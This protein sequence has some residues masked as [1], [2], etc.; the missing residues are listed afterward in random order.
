MMRSRRYGAIGAVLS[1]V[2]A[3]GISWAGPGNATTLQPAANGPCPVGTATSFGTCQDFFHFSGTLQ[4]F[5]VPSGVTELTLI[6]QGGAGA[7]RCGVGPTNRGGAGGDAD[8][9]LAVTTDETVSILVGGAG[10]PSPS[11]AD[12]CPP[13]AQAPDGGTGAGGFGGGGSAGTSAP[14]EV[15]G[16]QGNLYGLA[17]GGGG[18]SE[19]TVGSVIELVA[20]GGGGGGASFGG[21]G[22]GAG[23]GVG[24]WQPDATAG[25]SAE[26]NN[27]QAGGGAGATDTGSGVGG[28]AGAFD[29]GTGGTGGG[30]ATANSPATGGAGIST[31]HCNSPGGGGGYYGGGGGGCGAANNDTNMG[32]SNSGAGG[33]GSDF[34][35]P[36]MTGL[37]SGDALAAADGNG[38]VLVSYPQLGCPIPSFSVAKATR[39]PQNGVTTLRIKADVGPT[40]QC[41]TP[42]L[43]V[44]GDGTGRANFQGDV[45]L[46]MISKT[47]AT[48]TRQLSAGDSCWITGSLRLSQTDTSHATRK[49]T[50]AIT[51]LP[52]PSFATAT[53]KRNSKGVRANLKVI[54]LTPVSHCGR[55]ALTIDGTNIARLSASTNNQTGGVLVAKGV[56]VPPNDD[57]SKDLRIKATPP[58]QAGDDVAQAVRVSGANTSVLKV[59]S[60]P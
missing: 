27:D 26:N 11:P 47:V 10:S 58:H 39:A 32:Y 49:A 8:G 29:G 55:T 59:C 44:N 20:G 19:V 12:F 38:V 5:T 46:T 34:A 2:T 35:G 23:S 14:Q 28:T 25:S 52:T 18:A 24:G 30:P 42:T 15:Q 16:T 56:R 6:A 13:S 4:I 7:G 21:Q 41:G 17:G 57:C 33:G 48:A 22:A 43:T 45:K 3:T 31:L 40:K 54:S 50:D 37:F 1:V 36:D 51:T 53:A 60:K 9:T